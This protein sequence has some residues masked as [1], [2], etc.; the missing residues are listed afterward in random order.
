MADNIVVSERG[1]ITLPAALRK[2]LGI[3]PG[4][5]VQIEE[6]DGGL[7]LR[8]AVVLPLEIYSDADIARWKDEDRLRP[9]ERERLARALKSYFK[10]EQPT[11]RSTGKRSAKRTRA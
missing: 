5:V 4:A 10:G 1:Q 6:R 2:K 7:L 3:E 8:P 11:R 9:G